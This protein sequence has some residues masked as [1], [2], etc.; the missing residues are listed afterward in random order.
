[1]D[2]MPGFSSGPVVGPR[3]ARALFLL[4]CVLSAAPLLFAHYPP[5]IDVPQHAAQVGT[6]NRLLSGDFVH[7]DLYWI[8]W[9]TPY[10]GGY[11]GWLAL[12]WVLPLSLALK[13]LLGSV[14][15]AIPLVASRLRAQAG[16]DPLWDWLLLPIAYGFAFQW[17]LLNFL[18]GVPIAL[19]FLLLGFRYADNPR[20]LR[21]VLLAVFG[22][23]LVGVHILIAA[24]S[25]GLAFLYV[26]LTR[27]P[28]KARLLTLLPFVAPVPV[29]A[30]WWFRGKIRGLSPSVPGPWGLSASR[31]LELLASF[32][33]DPP[34]G[35]AA[36]LLGAV[37][38][39]LPFALGARLT[40]DR[41]RLAVF[42][43]FLLWMMLG[44]D[45]VLGNYK[46]FQRFA[47]FG[48]PL[49]LLVLVPPQQPRLRHGRYLRG[50]V[51]LIP[52]ALIVVSCVH[53]AGFDRETRDY[54]QL[55]EHMKPGRRVLGL[56]FWRDSAVFDLPMHV[57]VPSWYQGEAGGVVDLSFALYGGMPVRYRKEADVAVRRTFEWLPQTFDWQTHHGW[58]Y[59]YF[60][61]RDDKD[62]S[63]LI[64]AEAD[65]PVKL[66]ARVGLWWLY[67]RDP[68]RAD[69]PASC[70]VRHQLRRP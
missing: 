38:V 49:L 10:L 50:L 17:G 20:V 48:L 61:V 29:A 67:E 26:A 1:M 6:L 42:A 27:R 14:I 65:C 36:V 55:T 23:V 22:V 7:A 39:A 24:F 56:V 30:S 68:G 70:T 5:M 9:A 47:V 58:L 59:D 53:F 40:G 33:G 12:S 11:L 64:V 8:N 21:G 52:V 31:P 69:D 43:A 60:L 18:V 25:C 44:P 3:M 13:V 54:R 2:I 19:L 51:V 34:L 4:A 57:H 66:V 15:V 37:V 16:G 46:T 35:D 32:V 45:Y 41:R 62:R 63:A 28:W